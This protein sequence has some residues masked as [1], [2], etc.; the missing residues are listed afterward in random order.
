MIQNPEPTVI[1]QTPPVP[2]VPP[3]PIIISQDG[4]PI[5]V[6]GGA[7]EWIPIAGMLT[8]VIITAMFVLGPIGKAIGAVIRHWLGGGNKMESLPSEE[9][10]ELHERLELVTKQVA[11]LAERQDFTDRMLAQVRKE[12]AALPGT[13]DVAG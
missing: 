9:L 1:I 12:R 2:P 11:E 3:E 4:I 6:F 5:E 13:T 7:G 8:G 10:D